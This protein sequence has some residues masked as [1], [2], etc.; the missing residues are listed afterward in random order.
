MKFSFFLSFV[1]ASHATHD[2]SSSA[3]NRKRSFFFSDSI[4]R[5]KKVTTCSDKCMKSEKNDDAASK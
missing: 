3:E 4:G 1:Q 5:R 2:L